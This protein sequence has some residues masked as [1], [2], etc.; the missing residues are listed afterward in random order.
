MAVV[1]EL[2]KD[3]ES[4]KSRNGDRIHNKIDDATMK[5]LD[6][7]V[8]MSSGEWQDLATRY[9]DNAVMTRIIKQHY[10][11]RPVKEGLLEGFL[12]TSAMF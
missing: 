7:G 4:D 11:R 1:R 3:R 9:R 10:D 6:S 2:L 5:L 8:E 12:T